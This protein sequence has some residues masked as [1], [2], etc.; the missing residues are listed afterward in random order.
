MKKAR[1][2]F[3]SSTFWS[4]RIGP[5]AALKTLDRMNEI[6]SWDLISRNGDA[7]KKNWRLIAEKYDLPI[8]I[9]GIDALPLFAFH[10]NQLEYKTFITQEMLTH[11][12]LATN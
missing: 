10:S 12:I 5:A 11:N 6:N 2:S 9:S 7:I 8:S 1:E 4:D 3:I